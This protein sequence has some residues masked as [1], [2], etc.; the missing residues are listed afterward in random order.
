MGGSTIDK[1]VLLFK[2]VPK[3]FQDIVA[4]DNKLPQLSEIVW[5][6]RILVEQP[7]KSNSGRS[8]V[9]PPGT[10]KTLLVQAIA[11]EAEVPILVLSGSSFADGKKIKK[12]DNF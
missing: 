2:K 8:F 4:V 3:R 5:F 1:N 12:A 7:L 11:G 6:L 10:G 9:G